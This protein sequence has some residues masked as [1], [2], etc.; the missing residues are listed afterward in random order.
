MK[1][2]L[3]VYIAFL[4]LTNSAHADY[5]LRR[6]QEVLAKAPDTRGKNVRVWNLRQNETIRI[7]LVEF[8]GE[9]PLHKHPDGD[10]TLLVLDGKVRVQIDARKFEIAT[11]DLVSIPKDVPHKYWTLGKKAIL[12]SMD[13]PYYDPKKTIPLEPA[14]H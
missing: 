8:T 10:H 14:A 2:H 12:V 13:A 4:V 5:S 1:L 7:N 3:W 11:G 9:I 6:Y